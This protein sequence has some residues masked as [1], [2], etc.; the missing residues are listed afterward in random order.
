MVGFEQPSPGQAACRVIATVGEAV[1]MAALKDTIRHS[2][3]NTRA[4]AARAGTVGGPDVLQVLQ[5]C[6]Q[7]EDPKVQTAALDAL[8]L[9]RK[10]SDRN[11]ES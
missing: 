7:D 3:P 11:A 8:I 9:L 6:T 5:H 2:D 10:N 1:D 4:A